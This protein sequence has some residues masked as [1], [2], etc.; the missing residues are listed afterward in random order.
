MAGKFV[1]LNEAAQMVGVSPEELV[2]M[3]SKGEIF[4]YRDG[5]SWKFKTDEVERVVRE[6]GA[7]GRAGDSAILTANDDEF[8]NLIT[9]LS[10]KI[11]ADK[12]QEESEAGSVLISEDELGVSATGHSTIIGKGEKEDKAAADSDLR[13]AD[14]SSKDILGTGSD[15]LL[16][17]PASKLQATSGSDVLHS[18]DLK[19]AGGSGT[20]DMPLK[21]PGST[22]DLA[23]DDA[24]GLSEEDDLELE[25]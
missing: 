16:E 24:L 15:K 12:A 20:G 7:E 14:D 11:L 17:A 19:P 3:R 2:E 22:G 4:G 18:A 6:R 13:L 23:P 9:G 1:D 21:R 5:P 10:S 25:S 8:E